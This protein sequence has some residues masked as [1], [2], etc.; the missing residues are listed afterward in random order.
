MNNKR[1]KIIPFLIIFI[2]VFALYAPIVSAEGCH[3][4]YITPTVEPHRLHI[5][6]KS[7]P[8]TITFHLKVGNIGGFT[9]TNIKL[10]LREQATFKYY[11]TG[12]DKYTISSLAPGEVK[13]IDITVPVDKI[14]ND[15]PNN[16]WISQEYRAYVY[17]DNMHLQAW[18]FLLWE[19]A[20]LK[21]K[22][23]CK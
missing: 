15:C 6:V 14:Y 17:Y 3:I 16:G 10:Y 12:E 22:P 20:I 9:E 7:A 23:N 13:V 11:V 18:D 1:A 19:N 8:E 4:I 2:V 5:G 21:V